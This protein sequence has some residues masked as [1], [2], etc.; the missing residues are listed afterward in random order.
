M[1]DSER[2]LATVRTIEEIKPIDGADKICAYRVG[3]W[4]VIDQV[5]KYNV[6]DLVVYLEIDSWIPN[7]LAPFLSKGKEPREYEGVK[8]ERLRT[9]RLKGQLSQ[10]LLLPVDEDANYHVP[11]SITDGFDMTEAY[12]I[13]KWE[14]PIN[15]QLAGLIRGNFPPEIP[16]TP[17]E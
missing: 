4:W 12:G 6:G 1:Q 11:V 9:I 15:A 2:K 14:R 17:I 3:G 8:G 10:G 16:K 13:I 7:Y 5:G